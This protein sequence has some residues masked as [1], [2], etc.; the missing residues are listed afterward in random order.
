VNASPSK[1]GTAVTQ[2][3]VLKVSNINNIRK[4]QL[5]L[6]QIAIVENNSQQVLYHLY[7]KWAMEKYPV[8]TNFQP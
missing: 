4:K 5:A 3:R 1:L 8:F 2:P 6:E 7:L